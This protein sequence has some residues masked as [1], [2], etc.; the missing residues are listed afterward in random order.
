VIEIHTE[1]HVYRYAVTTVRRAK[2]DEVFVD[3]SET[4][5]MLTI[6]TCNTFGAKEDRFVVEARF[7]DRTTIDDSTT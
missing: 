5:T 7:V 1:K 4:E 2:A 3:L 6:S